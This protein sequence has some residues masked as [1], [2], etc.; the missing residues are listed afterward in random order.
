MYKGT[1]S[2]LLGCGFQVSIQFGFNEAS[3]RFFSRFKDNPE[4]ILP[5]NLVACS[6][7]VAG[8]GSGL[9]AVIII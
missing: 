2:P 4:D 1:L 5:L 8:I 9:I 6:G 3:K 7:F